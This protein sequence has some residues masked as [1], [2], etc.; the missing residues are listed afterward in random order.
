M[1]SH[2][3]GHELGCDVP[4]IDQIYYEMVRE[5]TLRTS[6]KR[7]RCQDNVMAR[8]RWTPGSSLACLNQIKPSER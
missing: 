6:N 3:S 2:F 4:K 5:K 8:S 1:F 7:G